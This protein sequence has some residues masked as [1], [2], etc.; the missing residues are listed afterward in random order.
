MAE[1]TYHCRNTV[2]SPSSERLCILGIQCTF[3]TG[4]LYSGF[5]LGAHP[6]MP[7]L[8]S[9]LVAVEVCS[10]LYV[11]FGYFILVKSVRCLS[12]FGVQDTMVESLPLFNV[13]SISGQWLLSRFS[14]LL[15]PVKW[16]WNPLQMDKM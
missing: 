3:M 7:I 14:G 15:T 11:V 9:P 16:L 4:T 12:N 8:P 5:E 10:A 6:R 2:Y 13:F 1:T